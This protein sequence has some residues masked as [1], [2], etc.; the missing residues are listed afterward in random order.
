MCK[1]DFSLHASLCPKIIQ[2]LSKLWLVRVYWSI[3]QL[4]YWCFIFFVSLRLFPFLIY[5]YTFNHTF[6]VQEVGQAMVCVLV[7]S[8]RNYL[9]CSVIDLI[10]Q[11]GSIEFGNW[12]KLKQKIWVRVWLHSISEPSQTQLNFTS[13]ILNHHSKQTRFLKSL[14]GQQIIK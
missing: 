13:N 1:M 3:I 10:E 4:W 14:Q 7:R 9:N 5:S 2:L 6:L 11:L 8:H 12:T